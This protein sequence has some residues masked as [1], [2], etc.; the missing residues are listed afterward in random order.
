MTRFKPEI[1]F[2]MEVMS[3]LEER[4]KRKI[5]YEG[6]IFLQGT[7]H[8]GGVALLWKERGMANLIGYSK[9]YVDIEINLENHPKWRFTGFYRFFDRK[10]RKESWQLLRTLWRWSNLPWCCM[11]DFNDT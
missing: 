11:G 10:R 2:L 5:H 1:V 7:G 9:T 3:N 8:G 6:L 4:I